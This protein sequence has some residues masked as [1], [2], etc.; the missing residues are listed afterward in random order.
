MIFLSADQPIKESAMHTLPDNLKLLV[1]IMSSSGPWSFMMLSQFPAS[2]LHPYIFLFLPSH[3]PPPLATGKA[4]YINKQNNDNIL[5]TRKKEKL[6]NLVCHFFALKSSMQ[7]WSSA[8]C[9]KITSLLQIS[10]S[11][12]LLISFDCWPVKLVPLPL[13][14]RGQGEMQGK[15][16][17]LYSE[18]YPT[19]ILLGLGF[20]SFQDPR[21]VLTM[22]VSGKVVGFCGWWSQ[23]RIPSGGV[24]VHPW[25]GAPACV[26]E[27]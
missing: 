8:G 25:G 24:C 10:T 1:G 14:L 26:R 27:V 11:A 7:F 23:G 2:P 3:H 17:A 16:Q 13:P 6:L 21:S 4:N 22:G 5:E 18:T 19:A 9:L 12:L 20:F 15:I